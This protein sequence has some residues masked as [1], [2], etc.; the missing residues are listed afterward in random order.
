VIGCG[1]NCDLSGIELKM[2]KDLYG[3]DIMS[4]IPSPLVGKGKGEGEIIFAD[5]Y[6]L[7]VF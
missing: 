1:A 2:H 4:L 3:I 5:S 7:G 6:L